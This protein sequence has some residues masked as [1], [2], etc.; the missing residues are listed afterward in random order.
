VGR[1][2]GLEVI[3]EQSWRLVFGEA[4][5]VFPGQGRD[6]GHH[7]CVGRSHCMGL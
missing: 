3:T 6:G 4:W 7:L 5:L 2:E 1:G